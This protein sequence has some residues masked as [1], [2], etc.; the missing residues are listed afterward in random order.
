MQQSLFTRPKFAP[1]VS[2][3]ELQIMV[4][5]AVTVLLAA[6]CSSLALIPQPTPGL[7]SFN[8]FRSP[9]TFPCCDPAYVSVQLSLTMCSGMSESSKFV[10]IIPTSD[11]ERYPGLETSTD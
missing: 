1:R 2:S 8:L 9:I 7:F 11:G 5:K 4:F 10:D 3:F 6:L